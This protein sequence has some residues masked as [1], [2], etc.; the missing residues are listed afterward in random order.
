MPFSPNPRH[1]RVTEVEPFFSVERP[2]GMFSFGASTAGDLILAHVRVRIEDRGGRSA[3]GWGAI[4]LSHP[5]A[6]PGA[7]PDGDIKNAL[8][9]ALV[10]ACGER[11]AGSDLWGHPLD[12]FLA[13]E[14]ELAAIASEAAS[15]HDVAVPVPALFNLVSLSPINAAIHDAYGNLHG[16][17]SYD[18]LGPDDLDWDLSRVLG[19]DYA[20]LYPASA[21]RPSP[22]RHVPISHTVGAVDPLTAAE[23]GVNTIPVLE[24]WIRRDGVFSFKVKVKGQDLDWDV[25]RIVDV[26]RVASLTRGDGRARIFADLNEQA[27]SVDYIHA[28]LDEVEARDPDARAALDALEQPLA[29]NLAEGAPSLASVSARIPVVL[30]EGLTSLAS[31]DRALELGWGGI[32]LKTCKTQSLMLLALAKANHERIH[33]SV[34]DLTN[35]GIAL[36]QS[37]GLAARLPVTQPIETNARQYYPETSAPEATVFPDIYRIHDGHASTAG[38]DGPGLGYGLDR[39]P[40]DIFRQ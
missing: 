25:G 30:D 18:A 5:W 17:S 16:V 14:P 2:A 8:M 6:F 7:T 21:L 15:E 38:L 27:P 23:A 10:T 13:I 36:R 40:R 11:L 20:G 28:L 4:F 32:A 22:V 19:G 26:Y 34:Q 35:P 1:V 39:I 37:V 29:R 31:I 33:V 24:E 9:K 3:E 12:H